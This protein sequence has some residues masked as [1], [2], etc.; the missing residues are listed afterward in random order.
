MKLL[1]TGLTLSVSLAS[2]GATAQR[3]DTLEAFGEALFFDE[4]LSANRTQSC[5]TCHDPAFGFTDPRETSVGRAVSLGDDGRSLGDRSAPT[6]A[7]TAFTPDF[8]RND[9]GQY[10]GGFFVD[11]RAAT[12]EDQ[13]G[14]PPLNPIEMGM[15]D[16]ASVVARLQ[17]NADYVAALRTHFGE[18]AAQE[19][20]AAF[21]GMTRALAAF[22]RT[23]LFAPFDSRYDHYLTGDAT[24][25]TEEEAGRKLFFDR[26]KT[27]C[28]ICHQLHDAPG[29]AKETFSTYR[30]HNIGVPPNEA[31]RVANGLGA[32]HVDKGL[33]QNP[34]IDQAAETGRF[35]VPT[36]RNVAVTGPYMHNGVFQDL[37]TVVL[38]YNKYNSLD[39]LRQVNPETG[40]R[41]RLPEVTKTLAVSDLI[42]GKELNDKEVDAIVAF[43]KTLTDARYEHLLKE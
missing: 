13:A 16:K 4:N 41:W 26:S 21:E 39:P 17:E 3:F 42:K 1:L 33:L 38:F 10:I 24:L 29:A 22:E 20:D 19:T 7:Y 34:E 12:L 23:D 28:S 2:G 9:K 32:A 36:L 35:K 43:L 30:Y 37:R 27:N 5:A 25:G 6:A 8:Y 40:E 31:V 18:A 11:G 14:E 15:P